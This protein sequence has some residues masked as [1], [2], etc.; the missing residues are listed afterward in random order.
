METNT[1]SVLLENASGPLIQLLT[2]LSG[3]DGNK[4]NE[5][6]KKFLRK[7]ETWKIPNEQPEAKEILQWTIWKTIQLGG[8]KNADE[9]RK[10]IK[11]AGMKISDYADDILGKPAFK[12][13][14]KETDIILARMTVAQL[15]FPN[16]ATYKNI[17]EKAVGQTTVINDIE[18]EV[19]LCPNEAGPAL[20]LQYPDQPKG[21]W[22]RIAMEA[23]T[24]SSGYRL[25]F[26]VAHG[27]AGLWL[28]SYDGYDGD[29]WRGNRV[30]VFCLRK[31]ISA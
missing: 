3:K 26:S 21:E 29:F 25:L 1:H 9:F 10:A 11:K 24:D 17:C 22:L 27:A 8:Y 2:N 12:V 7:E 5:E 30:F 31:K 28:R 14:A 23:I 6:L 20:R 15:G 13:E 18:Y 19:T 16:G 4:W